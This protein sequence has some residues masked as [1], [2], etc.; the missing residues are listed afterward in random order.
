[1]SGDTAGLSLATESVVI[2]EI[3]GLNDDQASGV[4]LKLERD[5]AS[6]FPKPAATRLRRWM[7]AGLAAVVVLTVIGDNR[8]GTKLQAVPAAPDVCSTVLEAQRAETKQ[9]ASSSQVPSLDHAS[10]QTP[11]M[12]VGHMDP[13]TGKY[14]FYARVDPHEQFWEF[15]GTSAQLGAIGVEPFPD[16]EELGQLP[17]G[18]SYVYLQ[19]QQSF[20]YSVAGIRLRDGSVVDSV[21]LRDG[22]TLP[23]PAAATSKA[24]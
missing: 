2:R 20:E 23:E 11:Y 8:F 17:D 3:R 22:K 19:D 7:F 15:C 6:A 4:A 16:E 10:S 12:S 18:M 5:S 21:E 13:E 9:A 24:R 14:T 1:M